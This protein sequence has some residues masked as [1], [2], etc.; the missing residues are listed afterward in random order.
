[1][2]LFGW[3]IERLYRGTM[4]KGHPPFHIIHAPTIP[5]KKSALT[6]NTF[7]VVSRFVSGSLSKE[8]VSSTIPISERNQDLPEHQRDAKVTWQ[9]PSEQMFYNAILRKGWQVRFVYPIYKRLVSLRAC[10]TLFSSVSELNELL[11]RADRVCTVT[12]QG[13]RH[14]ERHHHSQHGQREVLAGGDEV[15]A[16][17]QGE[18]GKCRWVVAFVYHS[19][20]TL[21]A[22][23][24][25]THWVPLL[26]RRSAIAQ[27]C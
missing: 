21:L 26:R 16:T 4:R 25:N 3:G 15:G 12:A 27:S 23:Q 14:D 1:M 2:A 6:I 11:T 7:V 18:R 24:T 9:Y 13:G 5:S 22:T 20:P 8:R 10:G 19:N 17:A